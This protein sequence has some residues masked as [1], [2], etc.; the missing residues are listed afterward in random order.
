M[1]LPSASRAVSCSSSPRVSSFG[2]S[3]G[4]ASPRLRG[5]QAIWLRPTR[6]L[7]CHHP[8]WA[9]TPNLPST[10]RTLFTKSTVARAASRWTPIMGR[11]SWTRT[12]TA[13]P[14]WIPSRPLQLLQSMR[15]RSL[16]H[17]PPQI[18]PRRRRRSPHQV[19]QTLH[20]HH[21]HNTRLFMNQKGETRPDRLAWNYLLG[22][23]CIET[24]IFGF[25]S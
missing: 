16:P 24:I 4:S 1:V 15:S 9:A 23:F 17:Q 20:T 8:K 18:P 3:V 10:R 14:N 21:Y 13:R 6:T 5:H 7:S 2:I 22:L 25:W 12:A 11:L 19:H